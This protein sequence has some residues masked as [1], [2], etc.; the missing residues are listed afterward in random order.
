LKTP[1]RLIPDAISTDTVECLELLLSEAK[2]GE[3]IGL[4]FGAM[5]RRR[6]YVVNTA[7]EAH[8]NPTFTRGMVAALDDQLSRR[9]HGPDGPSTR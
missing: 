2:R 1:F 4:A 5:L 6:A 9:V 7:G 8:R 3:V